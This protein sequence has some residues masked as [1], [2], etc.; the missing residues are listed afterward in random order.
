MVLSLDTLD[1]INNYAN[2]VHDKVFD[3]SLYILGQYDY[4]DEKLAEH[5]IKC[6]TVRSDEIDGYLRWSQE[7]S[8]P[9]IAANRQ[10]HKASVHRRFV[11]AHE[12]AH[13]V[14]DYNWD[15]DNPKASINKLRSLYRSNKEEFLDVVVFRNPIKSDDKALHELVVNEFASAFLIPKDKLQPIIDMAKGTNISDKEVITEIAYTFSTSL[16]TAEYRLKSYTN[17]L[18]AKQAKEYKENY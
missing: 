2:H 1:D 8:K 3:S 13:L 4:L 18:K 14:V 7:D 6:A 12:F 17:Y 16:N 11:Y 15:V 10:F 9:V 5:G